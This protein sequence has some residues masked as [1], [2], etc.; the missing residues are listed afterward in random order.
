MFRVAE[1]G[2]EFHISGFF[3]ILGV[4]LISIKYDSNFFF[5]SSLPIQWPFAVAVVPSYRF[6]S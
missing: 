1:F 5:I 2:F 4:L 6:F 3:S